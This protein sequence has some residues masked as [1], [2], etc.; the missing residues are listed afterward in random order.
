MA[1]TMETLG[2]T[3]SAASIAFASELEPT[4]GFDLA[5]EILLTPEARHR[6]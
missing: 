2:G 6:R 3:L 1:G 4:A 5:R